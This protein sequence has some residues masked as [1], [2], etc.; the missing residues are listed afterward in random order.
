MHFTQLYSPEE[1]VSPEF[2][3]RIKLN[4]S[5]R[6]RLQ[7]DIYNSKLSFDSCSQLLLIHREQSSLTKSDSPSQYRSTKQ[8][9]GS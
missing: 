8:T 3:N 9:A 4:I 5:K 7:L 1:T 6:R 2:K